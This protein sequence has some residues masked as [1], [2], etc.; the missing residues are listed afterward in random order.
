MNRCAFLLSPRLHVL[1]FAIPALILLIFPAAGFGS[2]YFLQVGAFKREANA[3]RLE[4]AIGALGHPVTVREKSISPETILHQVIVGPYDSR[5]AAEAGKKKLRRQGV[6]LEDAFVIRMPA[7]PL[8]QTAKEEKT[9]EDVSPP[10]APIPEKAPSSPAK[11]PP[12]APALAE[13]PKPSP[14]A[15]EPPPPVVETRSTTGEAVSDTA[16]DTSRE[17]VEPPSP[18][19]SKEADTDP[20]H[21]TRG[22]WSVAF[23]HSY[24]EVPT[25]IEKRTAVGVSGGATV[26][27]PVPTDTIQNADFDTVMHTDT[28]RLSLDIT[29]SFEIFAD[30]GMAYHDLESPRPVYGGGA[31]YQFFTT[32]VGEA[33]LLYGAL[34]GDFLAGSLEH[35]YDSDQGNRWRKEADWQD[36]SA[37]LE[38]GARFTRWT[39]F[40]GATYGLYRE[41]TDRTLL[42][43]IPAGLTSLVYKDEL[44]QDAVLGGFGGASYTFSPGWKALV[45]GQAGNRNRVTGQIQ[46]GF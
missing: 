24:T 32:G 28:L 12:G 6:F 26:S 25:Q 5:G 39:L 35:E 40:G 14:P 15:E 36:L 34:Q 10:P 29:D 4:K 37:R 7:L 45:E 2:E 17:E 16:R 33:G 30:A 8:T 46:Y 20:R 21:L 22:P 41:E 13:S 43:N 9:K 3:L 11:T 44:E 18:V 19:L 27:T 1:C 23:R 38:I 31:R 42:T